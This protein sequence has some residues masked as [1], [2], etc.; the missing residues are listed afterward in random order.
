MSV[1]DRA[2]KGVAEHLRTQVMSVAVVALALF[3]LGGAL[4]AV[5]NTS[6][7]AARWSA[8]VRVTVYLADG[9]SA[10]QIEALRDALSALPEVSEARYVSSSEVRAE[11]AR[12][13]AETALAQTPAELFPS[14]VELHLRPAAM[15]HSRAQDL[16][17][18]VRR[19]PTVADVE[20]YQGLGEQLSG[21]LG[22]TRGLAL[23]LALVV[24]A[25]S[26]AMVSNTVRLS[27][28]ARMREVEVLRL[29]GA[30]PEYVRRPFLVEG[31]L[32]GG[33]GATLAV[34]GL[35]ASFSWM[36]AHTGLAGVQP[37]FL[38]TAAVL[39]LLLGG[40]ALGAAGSSLALRRWLRV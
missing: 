37:L 6:S 36:R 10:S 35:W 11:L 32:L 30:T 40:G 12:G 20:T 18:R 16:A 9:A 28:S 25:C 7:L 26:I 15:D 22:A 19:L 39:S 4:L 23:V 13:G 1:L 5:E 24:L 14:T 38:S 2:L 31:A 27:L 33:G 34:L 3:C 8:P 29:V 21:M 17:S